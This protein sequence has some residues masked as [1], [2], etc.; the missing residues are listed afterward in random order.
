MAGRYRNASY[1]ALRGYR[2]QRW[3]G[4]YRYDTLPCRTRDWRIIVRP[5]LRDS[6]VLAA[7]DRCPLT[8]RQLL[9][10]SATFPPPFTSLRRVQERMAV[11]VGRGLVLRHQYAVPEA[12]TMNYCTLSPEG[13]RVVHGAEAPLPGHRFFEPLWAS[14]LPH[15]QALA[16]VIVHTA[17]AAYRAACVLDH[18]SRENALRLQIEEGFLYPDSAFRLVPPDGRTFEYFV[19]LDTGTQPIKTEGGYGPIER[20]IR[21]YEA[22]RDHC[23]ALGLD[24]R[25]RVLFVTTKTDE[26]LRHLLTRTRD[27][28]KKEN[29]N[30]PLV[31][32]ITL[33]SYLAL[34]RPIHDAAFADHRGQRRSLVPPAPIALSPTAQAAA[35]AFAKV[36]PL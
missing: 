31:Y 14:R 28:L 11:L 12:G 13:F 21:F 10:L 24:H 16:D 23:Q 9:R 3:R 19:E 25:F 33:A 8:V 2:K 20:K 6:A 32:G 26:R 22:Y 5:T 7:L 27:L 35:R 34:Q 15:T 29:K 17:V 4:A 1:R 30:R 18:F 36:G